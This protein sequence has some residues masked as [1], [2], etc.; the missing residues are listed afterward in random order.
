[1]SGTNLLVDTNFLIYLLNGHR[2]VQPYLNKNFFI[3]E[4][5]EME[6]LGV[7]GIS[8]AVLKI[9][10]ELIETCFKVSFGTDIKEI[11]IQIKQKATINLPDAIIAASAMYTGIPLVTADKE[12]LKVSGLD[13]QLL[14]I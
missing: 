10:S 8:P 1:M 5:S 3:S 2:S 14:K 13:V 11:A 4:I 7:K 12:F 9:R 6:I